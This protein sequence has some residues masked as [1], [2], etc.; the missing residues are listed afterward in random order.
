[1]LKLLNIIYQN[2]TTEHK[3]QKSCIFKNNKEPIIKEDNEFD[4]F[5]DITKDKSFEKNNTIEK[6]FYDC[7][8]NEFLNEFA[9]GI[10]TTILNSRKNKNSNI[11]NI[12]NNLNNS[13][14][15]NENSF[16]I[17]IDDL[18]LYNDF[19]QNKTEIQKFVIEFYLIKNIKNKTI[20]ELV[21][22]WKFSYKNNIEKKNNNNIDIN[23][24]KKK[25]V[26]LKKS[27]ISYSRLLPLYNYIINSEDKKDYSI[28]F[29]FYHNYSKKKGAFTNVPSGD[30]SL[31]NANLF[32]FKMNIKYYSEKE[33]KNVFNETEEIIGINTKNIK[34]KV[35]LSFH[36][37]N[38]S[39]INNNKNV[40]NPINYEQNDNINE[41]KTCQTTINN[42]KIN[43]LD[44]SP[45]FFLNIEEYNREE[46][47]NKINN[48]K[49][50]NNKI[51]NNKNNISLEFD[52]TIENKNNNKNINEG[53][54]DISCK[55]KYSIASTSYETTEE[56]TPINSELKINENKEIN[57]LPQIKK[58]MPNKKNK[59]E[60]NNILKEYNFLKEMMQ[61]SPSFIDI[62]IKKLMTYRCF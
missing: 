33:I 32:S 23:Y 52:K 11:I 45:P 22:K 62:K 41:I 44:E 49:I 6:T 28:D 56:C 10:F 61:K 43:E 24:L 38:Q 39:I 53:N 25:I 58:F 31:K 29:K 50:N 12:N 4:D 9:K 36:K 19:Y 27:I 34:K 3:K 26:I 47:N 54:N 8:K 55:R 20:K 48:N 35:S 51:N 1:M 42:N 16:C 59:K 14:K 30:V 40:N 46:K 15:N 18:F 17:D 57:S 37:S 2:K 21:E 13:K 5:I 7:N 60:V